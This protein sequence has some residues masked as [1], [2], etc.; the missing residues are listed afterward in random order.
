MLGYL[1]QLGNATAE[2]L[3]QGSAR[4]WTLATLK[5]VLVL[6]AK[7]DAYESE[8]TLHAVPIHSASPSLNVRTQSGVIRREEAVARCEA[9]RRISSD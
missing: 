1:R 3:I 5:R 4:E 6:C 9:D 7:G 8:T 2:S